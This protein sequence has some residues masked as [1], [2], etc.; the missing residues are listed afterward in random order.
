MKIKD[1]EI[2]TRKAVIKSM[3]KQNKSIISTAG[4][5]VIF[6]AVSAIALSH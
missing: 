3:Q 6:A 4:I 5:L 2:E 1:L